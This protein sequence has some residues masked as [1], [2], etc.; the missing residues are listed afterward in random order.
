MKKNIFNNEKKINKSKLRKL[1]IAIFLLCMIITAVVLYMANENYREV[2]DKYVFKKEIQE[3]NLLSIEIDTSKISGIYAYD[4]YL[5]VLQD[6]KLELYNKFGKKEGN[7]DIEIVTPDFESNGN[8]LVIA[9]KNGNRVYFVNGKTIV[10][11]K[12]V[13][14]KISNVNVNKNGYVSIIIQGTSYKTVVKT[15][16]SNG[17]ELFTSYHAST[18][19][20]AADVSNDNKYLAIAEVNYSGIIAQS[21]I[22]IISIEDAK[23]NSVNSIKYTHVANE[24]D[25]IVNIKYQ[26]K[27]NLICMYERHI[28]VLNNENN[29]NE[30]LSLKDKNILFADISLQSKVV[31]ITKKGTG[32]FNSESEMQIIDSNNKGTTTV[33]IENVPKSILIQ[34]NVIVVNLGTSALF[35][36]ENGWLQKKYESSHEIQNIL[37]CRELAG[38]VSKNKIELISL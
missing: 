27:N 38:I 7:I 31:S 8:Y 18:N 4:K 36:K 24:G 10:W 26:N 21:M 9:E 22:K 13:E 3:E 28:D 20:V 6:N 16:D 33:E 19:V 5:A 17:N 25:L 32:I 35:I 37:C 23:T 15:F 1:I 2:I 34:D 11:Q 29:N 30:L 12:D 14:G